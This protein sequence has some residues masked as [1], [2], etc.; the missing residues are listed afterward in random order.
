METFGFLLPVQNTALDGPS[1]R[2]RYASGRGEIGLISTMTNHFCHSCNRLRFTPDG[3]IRPCLLSD[4]EVDVKQHL[5]M[6]GSDL[7]LAGML[8]KSVAKKPKSRKVEKAG[9]SLNR[10]GMSAIG[11]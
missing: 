4:G 2:F 1:L 10:R 9:C 5:R 3:M 6:P 8:L 11:G 7:E